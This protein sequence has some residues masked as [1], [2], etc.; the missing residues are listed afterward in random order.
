MKRSRVVL[1][2]I[3]CLVLILSALPFMGGCKAEKEEAG[4]ITLNAV[5]P[6]PLFCDK[7]QWG[8][9]Q[10]AERVNE[11]SEGRLIID[12]L[13]GPEV[14]SASDAPD[15]VRTGAIDLIFGYTSRYT[16]KVPQMQFVNLSQVSPAEMRENGWHDWMVELHKENL[17]AYHLGL[18]GWN[19]WTMLMTTFPV[20]TLDDLKGCTIL[21][22]PSDFDRLEALGMTPI[23]VEVEDQYSALDRG[24]ADG[25]NNTCA[26]AVDLGQAPVLDYMM[27]P[28][29]H[30]ANLNV[31]VN[32]DKWNS[33]PK[34]LQQLMIDT[35]K[36]IESEAIQWF[37]K[38][39]QVDGVAALQAAGVEL[40]R[41]SPED[42][43]IYENIAYDF[44]WEKFRKLV[45]EE[46]YQKARSLLIVK[47][48][49]DGF[50]DSR[51][52]GEWLK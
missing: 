45:S 41:F 12:I 18:W 32:L 36:E 15:A 51:G 30:V 1:V 38:L 22:Y 43:A 39:D 6:L 47:E 17:N 2:G 16:D 34:D 10:L 33:L 23:F 52:W 44:T 21:S 20:E 46:D 13:G 25:T 7:V 3:L 40:G 26:D 31:T 24:I 9:F 19:M 29:I 49:Y 4:P 11:R 28:G 8:C 14:I 50:F 48:D 27:L 5:V 42:S 35:Q 37:E